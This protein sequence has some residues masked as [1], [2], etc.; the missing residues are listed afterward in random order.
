MGQ[1]GRDV[2]GTFINSSGYM[3]VESN[4]MLAVA[5][6]NLQNVRHADGLLG[7]IGSDSRES[8]GSD[9]FRASNLETVNGDL[10]LGRYNYY[11]LQGLKS[12]SGKCSLFAFKPGT[13]VIDLGPNSGSN[14]H[15]AST[16]Q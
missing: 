11:G 12:I 7:F 14:P 1:G 9:L 13:C 8:N 15:V 6:V 3:R 4:S 10:M 5:A 2:Q 16:L